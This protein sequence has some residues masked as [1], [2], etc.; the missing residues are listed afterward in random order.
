MRSLQTESK[1]FGPSALGLALAWLLA[2]SPAMLPI[3]GASKVTSATSSARAG[4]LR[5]SG[6]DIAELDAAF[7]RG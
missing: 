7:I 3:P 6:T 2:C 4:E 1:R 5:L